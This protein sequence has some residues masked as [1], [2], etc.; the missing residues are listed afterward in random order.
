MA[1]QRIELY[2]Q[3]DGRQI[4]KVILKPTRKYPNGYFYIDACFEDLVRRRSWFINN[5]YVKAVVGSQ[6]YQRTLQLHQEIAYRCLGKYPK[7]IDH[8]NGLGI[9]NIGLNL[10]EV[11]NQQN[12]RN[13]QSRGYTIQGIFIP[14]ITFNRR[15]IFDTSVCREDEVCIKQFQ[16]ESQMYSDYKYDFLKDRRNDLDIVDLERRGVISADESTFR[17]VMRYA[18][19]NAWYVW[20]FNLF[21]YF[22]EHGVPIP[23]YSLNKEGRMVD[24]YGNLLCPFG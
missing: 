3:Q 7:Y 2:T 21:D 10:S 18:E 5:D 16:F 14:T 4:L 8:E 9:D 22:A 11:T 12:Q 24:E 1:V 6:W 13:K 15:N 17:H 20:R 23:V 19:N